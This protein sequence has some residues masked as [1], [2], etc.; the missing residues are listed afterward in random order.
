MSYL[1]VEPSHSLGMFTESQ[2]QCR[3]IRM[4][5]RN[6]HNETA[7]HVARAFDRGNYSKGAEMDRFQVLYYTAWRGMKWRE[8]AC[9]V[10]SY[11]T[12]IK[13]NVALFGCLSFSLFS[14]LCLFFS[15]TPFSCSFLP[16]S[17]LPSSPSQ[18]L[19]YTAWR[20]VTWHDMSCFLIQYMDFLKI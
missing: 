1:I 13:K 11:S 14:F 18:I 2:A 5:H 3:G 20:D 8:V 4:V 9:H 19:Y 7:E 12:W 15:V 6:C 10:F 17:F 16:F